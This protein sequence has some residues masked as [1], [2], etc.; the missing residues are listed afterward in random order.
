MM[1]I[2][3]NIQ[4]SA[5]AKLVVSETEHPAAVCQL[6]NTGTQERSLTDHFCS[7][8]CGAGSLDAGSI[9]DILE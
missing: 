6:R 5:L 8:C 3:R 4:Y 2:V 7:C 1:Y 9:G